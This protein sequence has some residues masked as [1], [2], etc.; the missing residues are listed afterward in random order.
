MS[1][2]AQFTEVIPVHRLAYSFGW[3]EQRQHAARLQ[4]RG[5]R[6]VEK[7]GGT[8]VRFTHSGL[9]NE[10]ERANHEKGWDHYLA[11]SPWLRPAAIPA[12]ID[13]ST[14]LPET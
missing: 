2:A 6:P 1:R 5:D 14:R 9:P 7:D 10:T 13:R 12:P 4:P 11:G 3:E 8:L